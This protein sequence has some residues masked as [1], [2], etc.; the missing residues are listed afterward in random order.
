M[1]NGPILLIARILLA[2]I[3]IIA[4]A[5]K[6]G[7]IEGVAG[8]IG[9]K[10]I[11]MPLIL[12]WL[13]AIGEVVGGLMILVG[14]RTQLACYGLAAFCVLAG[15]IF[16]FDPSSQQEMQSFMKNLAIA[17]GFLALSVAGAGRFS[18]DGRGRG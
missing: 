14:F 7:G 4:G 10:G 6:F 1:A 11:P 8:Y 18:I 5:S 12:A 16:H 9:S 13:T 17:G 15:V 2:A 3:F